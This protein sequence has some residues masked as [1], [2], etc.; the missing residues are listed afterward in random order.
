MKVFQRS[1]KYISYDV[2]NKFHCKEW[3]ADI[4][5]DKGKIRI[6]TYAV[7]YPYDSYGNYREGKTRKYDTNKIYK[8]ISNA[9]IDLN[10]MIAKKVSEGYR[11]HSDRDNS[12]N[13]IQRKFN[14]T[15]KT[16]LEKYGK[17]ITF[18]H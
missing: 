12:F 10:R 3:W 16:F 15:K 18:S 13:P 8:S 9:S 4:I 7:A 17:D 11:L 5:K 6:I 2:S 1:A 14:N